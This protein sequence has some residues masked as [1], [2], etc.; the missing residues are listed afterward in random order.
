MSL[1][2]LTVAPPQFQTGAVGEAALSSADPAS[3]LNATR[4][5]ALMAA[6][7]RGAWGDSNWADSRQARRDSVLLLHSL[8]EGLPELDRKLAQVRPNLLLIGAM[9][10]CL[11][12][13]IACA[14]RAK[15]LL[16]ESVCVVL[17]GRHATESFWRAGSGL[18]V[19]HH[20]SSPLRLMQE[21]AIDP[22]FDVVVSGEGEHVIVAI[23]EL[24]DRVE[25]LGLPAA[26]ARSLLHECA[27]ARGRW[28]AGTWLDGKVR[29]VAGR[30]GDIDRSALP[31]PCAMF[32]VSTRFDVFDGRLT[33][34]VFS[35]V[36]SGCIYDCRFC[37]ERRSV[38]GL[39]AQ[40]DTSAD[41]LFRQL[42]AAVQVIEEDEPGAGASAFVEDSTLL[43]YS[44]PLVRR[45]VHLLERAPMDLRFGGQLTID[46]ILARP[47]LLA[48]LRAVGFDYLFLGL[49][50]LSPGEIGG[51]SK[52]V[53]RGHGSWAARAEAVFELLA[54]LGMRCGAAILC[55]LGE[56]RASRMAL[57]EQVGIWRARYGFPDPISMNWAVQHPLRGDDGGTG[58]TYTQWANPGGPLL[59][60]FRDFGEASVRYPLAG[61]APPVLEEVYELHQAVTELRGRVGVTFAP[62]IQPGE[63]HA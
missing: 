10:I 16:G 52:D 47:Q 35:D 45:L 33:A 21:G 20:P 6:R 53:R 41:R 18:A 3:L 28:L 36:G 55:G 30:G 48:E 9:S 60:L 61:Q 7:G 26:A 57:V 12:G 40:L 38:T 17:G 22:V 5:A 32:G 37:S 14:R 46:Q 49:E 31:A 15:A 44:P 19:H 59:E 58:Y 62:Q 4:L 63:R 56:S 43:T 39:P 13:A 24:V 11:P 23:G 51:M 54:R 29:T 1:R 25:R 34:H 8:R 42:Q 2:V 27:D 50:T